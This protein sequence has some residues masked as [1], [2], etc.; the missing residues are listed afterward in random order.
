MCRATILWVEVGWL[1][2][3]SLFIVPADLNESHPASKRGPRPHMVGITFCQLPSFESQPKAK[4]AGEG[5]AQ[6][7]VTWTATRPYSFIIRRLKSVFQIELLGIN[8]EWNRLN[9]LA[10][11]VKTVQV[12]AASSLST[13]Q[14]RWL[15][16]RAYWQYT[17]LKRLACLP[18][19]SADPFTN[20]LTLSR[21]SWCNHNSAMSDDDRYQKI[22][23]NISRGRFWSA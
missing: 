23:S 13:C 1:A 20:T 19:S 6:Q 18:L 14:W 9:V 16:A 2:T 17:P 4:G 22:L 3:P 5:A 12:V 15:F 7:H 11:G 10:S 21:L 8:D